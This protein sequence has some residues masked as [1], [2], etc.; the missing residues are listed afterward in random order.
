MGT[1][2]EKTCDQ[3][4]LEDGVQMLGAGTSPDFATDLLSKAKK[5]MVEEGCTGLSMISS[6]I[7]RRQMCHALVWFGCSRDTG[8]SVLYGKVRNGRIDALSKTLGELSTKI[9]EMPPMQLWP[10]TVLKEF[11][12][13]T[14]SFPRAC[15]SCKISRFAPLY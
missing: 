1:D 11:V 7:D 9:P 8:F 14:V 4:L 13:T 5:S 3:M 10:K 12:I 15:E 2:V 6:V